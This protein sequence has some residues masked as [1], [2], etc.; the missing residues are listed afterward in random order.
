MRSSDFAPKERG[1]VAWGFNPRCLE[2][3]GSKPLRGAGNVGEA[4]RPY[5]A[6]ECTTRNEFLG[7]KP[8]A[9]GRRRFAAERIADG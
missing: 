5:R 3:D 8:Q 1:V 2:T 6:A 4:L 7:L 9:V